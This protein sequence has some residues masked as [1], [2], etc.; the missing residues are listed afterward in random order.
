LGELNDWQIGLIYEMAMQYPEE[1]VRS[2]FFE[3]KKSVSNLD[4]RD[5]LDLGYS[6]EE[7]AR[8]KGGKK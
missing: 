5:M 8:I 1:W 2:S 7:I 6:R 3:Q 4:D